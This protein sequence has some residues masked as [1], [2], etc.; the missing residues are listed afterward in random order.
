MEIKAGF[1][2]G[3]RCVPTKIFG[4]RPSPLD[5]SLIVIHNITLPPAL[6]NTP[7][8]DELFTMTLNPNEHPYF[9]AIAHLELST[10]LFINRQGR[11]TQYVSFLDRAYHAGRSSYQGRVECNDFG[12]GIELEGTDY[13]PYTKEQYQ[14]LD[15][16]IKAINKAYPDTVGHIAGHNE[17]AP[18][19]KSDPGAFFDWQRYR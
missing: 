13:C 12:I 4:K 3:V 19:R 6:F 16:C 10:H 15:E 14:S 7:Y 18:L 1:L 17:V 8:V 11:I 9:K 2:Q 5:I